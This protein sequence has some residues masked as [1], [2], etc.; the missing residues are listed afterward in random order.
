MK[1]EKEGGLRYDENQALQG[2]R[3]AKS[4]GKSSKY[5]KYSKR[6]R[7]STSSKCSSSG[8]D[9]YHPGHGR[10]QRQRRLDDY[11]GCDDDGSSSD[12]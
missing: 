10:L 5:S 11:T 4:M 3:K 2:Q 12:D 6:S 1:K 8:D 9:S 7:S